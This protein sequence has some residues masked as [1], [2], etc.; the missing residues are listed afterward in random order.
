M[1]YYCSI[2]AVLRQPD[3]VPGQHL[4]LKH[5]LNNGY[6]KHVLLWQSAD[7]LCRWGGEAHATWCEASP[8]EQHIVS[9]PPS[10][11]R[12]YPGWEK[13]VIGLNWVEGGWARGLIGPGSG[14]PV[15]NSAIGSHPSSQAS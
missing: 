7:K 10:G 3:P 1:Q 5:Y 15:M 14:G 6:Y 2:I 12:T 13:G 11:R 9:S 4:S 8:L